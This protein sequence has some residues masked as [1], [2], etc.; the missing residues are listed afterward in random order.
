MRALGA[1]KAA[2]AL[3]QAQMQFAIN[4]LGYLFINRLQLKMSVQLAV[5][6]AIWKP[7]NVVYPTS[8]SHCSLKT[9]SRLYLAVAMKS[10]LQ[11]SKACL[12][13]LNI[14]KQV[15]RSVLLTLMRILTYAKPLSRLLVPHFYNLPCCVSSTNA[16]F[17]I[18]V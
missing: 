14:I 2:K 16:L 4:W 7:H 3:K 6:M 17:N 11:A 10:H 8:L 5:M 13:M 18:Y 12:T 1:I 9:K 15:K